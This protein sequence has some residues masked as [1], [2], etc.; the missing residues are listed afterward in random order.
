MHWSA[1]FI[2]LS[3]W[4]FAIHADVYVLYT[5]ALLCV[6]GDACTDGVLVAIVLQQDVCL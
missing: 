2:V 5:T 4:S 6:L 1:H 3:F